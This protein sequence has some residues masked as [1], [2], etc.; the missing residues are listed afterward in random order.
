MQLAFNLSTR[1]TDKL[2]S[3]TIVIYS[4]QVKDIFTKMLHWLK[5][6]INKDEH[7][8]RALLQIKLKG[9]NLMVKQRRVWKLIFK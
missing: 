4:I 7:L 6:E 9:F 8:R 1:V 3:S 5:Q 2:E